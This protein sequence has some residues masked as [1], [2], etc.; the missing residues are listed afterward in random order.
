VPKKIIA[1]SKTISLKELLPEFSN[2]PNF[3]KFENLKINQGK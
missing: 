1:P 3:S 2:E